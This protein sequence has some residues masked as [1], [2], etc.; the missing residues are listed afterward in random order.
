MY[1]FKP[2]HAQGKPVQNLADGGIVHSLTGM[3]GMRKRT[4]EEMLAADAK[5]QERNREAAARVAARAKPAQQAA[6]AEENAV[7]SYAGMSAMQRREQAAGLKD[8]GTVGGFKPGGLIRGPGTGT[9][10]SIKTEK[11]PG[12]FIM[13]AD[14]TQAIG[15]EALEELGK[16]DDSAMEEQGEKVPVRLSNGEFELPPEQVQA[17]GEAVLTVMRNATHQPAGEQGEA[18]TGKGFTPHQ[19]FADGGTV[20]PRGFVAG[21]GTG[22][23]DSIPARLSNGEYVLPA[24]TVKAVGVEALDSLRAATHTPVKHEQAKAAHGFFAGGTPGGVDEEKLKNSFGDAAA[25]AR[26]ASVTQVGGLANNGGADASRFAQVPAPIGTQPGRTPEPA[27]QP[28]APAPTAA[29]TQSAGQPLDAQAASDRAKLGAAWDTVKDVNDSAGRAIADV[30]M[31]APRAV[32]GAYDSAVVRPMRAAGFN[33]GYLSPIL[34]PN[35]VDP[36]SMTPYADQKRMQEQAGAVAPSAPAAT[37]SVAATASTAGA[38]RGVVNP[39]LAKPSAPAPSAPQPEAKTGNEIMPGVFKHGRGQYSDQSTGMNMPNGFTGQPNAQNMA[40]ADALAARQTPAG[41]QPAGSQPAGVQPPV[42]RNS[43][44]DWAARKA[45]ENMATAASSITNTRRWGGKGAENSQDVQ[46][47]KAALAN[48]LALQQ[49]QPNMEQAAMRENAG[50]TREGM[51]QEG[52]TNRTS[53]QEQGSNARAAVSSALQ[54]DEFG[55]KKEVAGFQTRAAQQQEQLRNV[56]VDPKAT[57]EQRAVAQRNLAALSGKTA[58]DRM[59][60]VTLPDTTN[61][62]GQVVRGGQALVR[63][64]EDGT[65]QQV[66]IGAQAAAPI[67]AP[68]AG[69]VR[70]GFRFKGGN[71]NDQANWTKV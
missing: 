69:E 21:K 2:R 46:A 20:K 24:D 4:P 55:L 30:A 34:V 12:T 18:P 23:S 39:P 8:G 14:S 52:A 25:V 17:L 33:A 29:S 38:G 36:S 32:V 57:P 48:D 40:A 31:L 45:L 54:R 42:V 3:L 58:A 13:P 7:S 64:L 68:K 19:F 66:P 5:V 10:D 51:Q 35:G 71:P 41:F 59:Q 60:T 43:T 26:D 56:L 1:G 6:P 37:S 16:V 61:E 50:I 9:S 70:N 65:V 47:Y 22:T 62:M 28:A 67:A 15:P 11:R 49:A 63:V 44:N 53:M 27:A